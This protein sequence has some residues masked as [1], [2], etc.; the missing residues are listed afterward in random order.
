MEWAL[1]QDINEEIS[2]RMGYCYIDSAKDHKHKIY[3]SYMLEKG[4]LAINT[5]SAT[6]NYQLH[7]AFPPFGIIRRVLQKISED[8]A[9]MIRVAPLFPSQPWFPQLLQQISR[10][11]FVLPKTDKIL[12]LPEMQRKYRLTTGLSG[13]ALS[14]W[15]CQKTVQASSCS[16]GDQQEGNNM[17]VISRDGCNFVTENK[18]IKLIHL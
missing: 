13:N 1:Q 12:F 10:Q 18:L 11:S 16:R 3:I 17:G 8:R 9:E 2:H 6:W 14:V 5:F 7:Y 15:D 4:A